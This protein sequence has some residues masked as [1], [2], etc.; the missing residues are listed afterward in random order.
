MS[1]GERLRARRLELGLSLDEV[2]ERTRIPRSYLEVIEADQLHRL[3]PGSYESGHRR[4]LEQLYAILEAPAPV[5]TELT[6]PVL[7]AGLPLGTVRLVALGSIAAL[8]GTL[9][10]QL[11]RDPGIIPGLEAALA[12]LVPVRDQVVTVEALRTVRIRAW[13]DGELVHD[14]KLPGGEELVLE[15]HARIAL[16]VPATDAIRLR[17]NGER[18]VPLG[19]RTAPRRLFFVDDLEVSQ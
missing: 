4:S 8:L 9:G 12:P 14:S 6:H 19:R 15:A 16:E 2:A 10:L 18:V 17:Y 5:P 1:T 3:P 11:W 7:R 13:E